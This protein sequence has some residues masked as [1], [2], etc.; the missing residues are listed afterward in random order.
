[1]ARSDSHPVLSPNRSV[2]QAVASVVLPDADALDPE[3]WARCE[4]AMEGA[5][6]A[7]PLTVRRQVRLFLRVVNLLPVLSTGRS[8]VRLSVPGRRSFLQRLQRSQVMLLRRGLWGVRTLLFMGYYSQEAVRE[9]IG[10]RA[11]PEGWEALPGSR[12]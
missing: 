3:V 9:R 11:R 12:S 5:L 4:A 6:E 10:Y 7:R 8:L 1:M 2:L